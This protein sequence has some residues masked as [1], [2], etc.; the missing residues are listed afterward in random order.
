[1][2]KAADV[3]PAGTDGC[4]GFFRTKSIGQ[5][6]LEAAN[7]V[8]R[9]SVQDVSVRPARSRRKETTSSN[10]SAQSKLLARSCGRLGPIVDAFFYQRRQN[11]QF[12]FKSIRR[13]AACK[14][15]DGSDWTGDLAR[16]R[17]RLSATPNLVAAIVSALCAGWISG[18]AAI[19]HSKPP[20]QKGHSTGPQRLGRSASSGNS[21][22]HDL[23]KNGPPGG[24]GV[25]RC[26]Y[27]PGVS[28][29]LRPGVI[30]GDENN[31]PSY[32]FRQPTNT[33]AT[34]VLSAWTEH[35]VINE[36]LAFL[37][38]RLW[39]ALSAD[40]PG[41]AQDRYGAAARAQMGRRRLRGTSYEQGGTAMGEGQG[42]PAAR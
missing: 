8:G 4:G 18:D 2:F 11:M 29:D 22:F 21:H 16:Q 34:K 31:P 3:Q 28:A 9:L 26:G 6:R 30:D 12:L 15:E 10:R 5:R 25:S 32:V 36:V 38:G 7:E 41:A 14:N 1:V 37:Q 20:R 40:D 42:G 27:D 35:L 17:S 23:M 39:T 13:H 24:N 33:A 19:Y